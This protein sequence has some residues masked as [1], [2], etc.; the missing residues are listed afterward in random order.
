MA[1]RWPVVLAIV[2]LLCACSAPAPVPAPDAASK[3][4]R[5]N[6][7][8]VNVYSGR[9]YDAD[10][11]LYQRF[12]AET[13]IKVR[14]LEAPGAQLLERLKVE[15]EAS[16]ADLI[17]T[18][19]AGNLAQLK[20]ADLLAPVESPILNAAIPAKLRD[21]EGKWFGLTKRARVIVFAK[22]DAAAAEVKS[23]ADLGLPRYKGRVCVRSSTNVYNLSFLS[24]MISAQ[25]A[26]AAQ[27]WAKAVRAN[28]AREPEGSDT[29]Q[30]KAVAAGACSLAIVNHYY[31]VRMLSSKDPSER[32]AA[33]LVQL[34]FP[35]QAGGGTHINVSGAGLAKF[36][37]HR[38]NA[39]RLLEFLVN[40]PSQ[41]LLAEMNDEFPVR[42]DVPAADAV[43][44]LGPF[45]ESDVPLDSFGANQAK[46]QAIF[47]A[48]DWR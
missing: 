31:L 4:A 13:G 10:G 22:A 12:E 14:V 25:G 3:P 27:K 41:T 29:D 8:V 40:M 33:A 5:E 46:A 26:E 38:E 37:A 48:V 34:V 24:G 36:A 30:I 11:V 32:Q 7:A 39:Q 28:F 47:D 43:A 20:A 23:Y 9:H 16:A 15:G 21:S 17:L 45:K 19:D 42:A 2:S 6:E 18:S 1:V 35:D 44:A